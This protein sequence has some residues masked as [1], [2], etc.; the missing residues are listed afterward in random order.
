MIYHGSSADED[1]SLRLGRSTDWTEIGSLFNRGIGL[2]EWYVDDVKA[3]PLIDFRSLEL[4][5]APS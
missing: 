5:S 1:V 4:A 2:K 3:I